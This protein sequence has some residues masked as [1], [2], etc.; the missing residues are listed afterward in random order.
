MKTDLQV[1]DIVCN[2]ACTRM[3]HGVVILDEHKCSYHS[4]PCREVVYILSSTTNHSRANTE[5]CMTNMTANGY[6]KMTAKDKGRNFLEY[7]PYTDNPRNE[8]VFTHLYVLKL[9]ELLYVGLTSDIAKVKALYDTKVIKEITQLE[10]PLPRHKAVVELNK[11]KFEL[12]K[13][14][15]YK[16]VKEIQNNLPE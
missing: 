10:S 3:V 15:D 5:W 4:I 9:E 11:K 16:N 8:P 1:Y 12:S 6:H 14:S 7:K 13:T 2:D